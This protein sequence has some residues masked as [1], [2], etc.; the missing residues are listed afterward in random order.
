MTCSQAAGPSKAR[1]RTA[2]ARSGAGCLD[3][4]WRAVLLCCWVLVVDLIAH[5]DAAWAVVKGAP[6]IFVGMLLALLGP[7]SA[8]MF[9]LLKSI[10]SS[11]YAGTIDQLQ[12]R[13]NFRDDQLKNA[14]GTSS[15][16][17]IK[18]KLDEQ[19]AKIDGL[20][21]EVAA[22]K[23]SAIKTTATVR[24]G[25][26]YTLKASDHTINFDTTDGAAIAKMIPL[27]QDQIGQTWTFKWEKWGEKMVLPTINAPPGILMDSYSGA[28]PEASTR[29]NTPGGA[30][31]LIWD[32]TRL[33][34]T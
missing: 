19:K 3:V 31:T 13:I 7:V 32:G 5:W 14:A 2:V 29:I 33:G 23:E 9:W 4:V 21:A 27:T 17:E 24:G 28:K 8:G 22:L 34:R 20:S 1:A 15:P 12:E 10:L 18:A 6:G 25:E 11:R 26:T 30:Y 16:D